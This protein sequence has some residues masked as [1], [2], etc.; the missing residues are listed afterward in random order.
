METIQVESPTVIKNRHSTDKEFLKESVENRIYFLSAEKTLMRTCSE[1][2]PRTSL[3]QK[4]DLEETA[5]L[6]IS[7]PVTIEPQRCK[8]FVQQQ[9]E[10]RQ[11]QKQNQ[12]E[13]RFPN[14]HIATGIYS[15]TFFQ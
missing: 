8:F 10:K 4:F 11:Q 5:I 6:P 3:R 15:A 9:R 7:A 2:N 14:K 1:P 13:V 12:Y